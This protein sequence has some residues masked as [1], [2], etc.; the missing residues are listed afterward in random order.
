MA[1]FFEVTGSLNEIWAL[2]Q[3]NLTLLHANNKVADQP[4]HSGSLINTFFIHLLK[5]II[6][7]LFFL[8]NFNILASLG[9]S[10]DRF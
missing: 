9:S 10:T 4:M 3:E 5:S 2:S 1:K 6:S 8:Q 7:K